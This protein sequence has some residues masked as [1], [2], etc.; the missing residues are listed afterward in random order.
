MP[1]LTGVL[2]TP[3]TTRSKRTTVPAPE[4][5]AGSAALDTLTS[6]PQGSSG[7]VPMAVS[8]LHPHPANPAH[9]SERDFEDLAEQIRAEGRITSPL[10]VRRT[11]TVATGY[12]YEVLSGSRRLAAAQFLGMLMV[13]VVIRH[14]LDDAAALRL[15]LAENLNR[16]DF[17]ESEQADLVQGILDLGLTEA[18]V[19]EQLGK[20]KD[21]VKRRRAIAKL[22]APTKAFVDAR[23]DIEDLVVA[24]TLAEFADDPDVMDDLIDVANDT[25]DRF[26]QRVDRERIA[27]AE[28]TRRAEEVARFE[29]AGYQVLEYVPYNDTS[30]MRLDSLAAADGGDAITA[31]EHDQCP[32]RAV[33]IRVRTI[34]DAENAPVLDVDVRHACAAW[35]TSG[36][37]NRFAS[38]SSGATS[39][40]KTDEQKAELAHLKATN[41]AALAAAVE[42][43]LWLE[44]F[45][46][47]GKLPDDAITYTTNVFISGQWATLN[48]TLARQLLKVPDSTVPRTPAQALKHLVAL[49]AAHVE[50]NWPKDYW[51]NHVTSN[52]T[53]AIHLTQLQSWG[54]ELAPH[55]QDVVTAWAAH[56]AKAGA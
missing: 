43:R 1:E 34:M 26:D 32:G 17:T 8:A 11:A 55:E 22:D 44:G 13:D 42:R 40:P 39:G 49:A 4:K 15:V 25:P 21:W 45:L 2:T 41:V 33:T 31:D 54:Y 30:I 16:M 23:P 37:Y 46:Q 24:A 35:K 52:S 7:P 51:R 56:L 5:P 3:K 53:I 14:D 12:E 47:R 6:G 48:N 10:I 19:A 20:G 9:R 28:R 27:R 38:P 36:H 18:Q 50:Q 29:A